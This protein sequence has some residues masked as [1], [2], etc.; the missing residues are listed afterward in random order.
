MMDQE[1]FDIVAKHLLTQNQPAVAYGR[2]AYRSGDLKCAVGCLID[3]KNYNEDIE[4]KSIKH[5]KVIKAVENS[6][7]TPLSKEKINFLSDL[8]DIHDH[9]EPDDWKKGLEDFAV[10]YNLRFNHVQ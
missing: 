8:Q 9:T 7:G 1:L 5:E 6:L 3:D 10:N 4:G 2:C